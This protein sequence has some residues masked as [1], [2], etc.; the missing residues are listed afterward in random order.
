MPTVKLL[1]RAELELTEAC[2]W[3][4]M[5]KQGLSVSLRNEV[6]YSLN[7]IAA[8]PLLYSRRNNTTLRFGPLRKFPYVVI[9]WYDEKI[10]VI[11]VTSIFHT[12]RKPI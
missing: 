9:Y 11:F 2:D 1:K 3:Y 12:K 4:E 5:Q 7:A 10:D 6:S 8:N